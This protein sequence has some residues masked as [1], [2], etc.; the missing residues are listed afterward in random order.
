MS[1]GREYLAEHEYEFYDIARRIKEEAER[2]VWTTK[3][4]M[5]IPV[6]EMT[7]SHI[8]NTI[9]YIERK[10]KYDLYEPWLRVFRAELESREKGW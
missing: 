7:T 10:D 5:E 1:L 2:G 3:D 8:K 4:G 9:A 6:E